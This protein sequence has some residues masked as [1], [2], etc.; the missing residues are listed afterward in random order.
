[1]R[2]ADAPLMAR[3]A[4]LGIKPG[5]T[6]KLDGFDAETRTAI[7]EGVTA[8]QAAIRD[9]ES[10]LGEMVNGW[11]VARDLGRYG[12][13]YAYRAT[14]TFFG[15]GGN[16]VEVSLYPLGLVDADGKKFDGANK[17][18]L[19]FPKDEIPPVDAFW[20]LTLYDKDS[21][22]VDNPINR[23]ALGDRSHCTL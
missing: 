12:T 14:W 11:Q 22:L 9:G 6:F 16:I 2:Q 15:V 7:A 17:Y 8:G 13:K 5:A 19:R 1:P 18:V 4:A 23:Y 10:K 20:S 3:L 21:Y